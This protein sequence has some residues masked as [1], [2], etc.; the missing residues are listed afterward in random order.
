[1][2]VQG[3]KVIDIANQDRGNGIQTGSL[4]S[5]QICFEHQLALLDL[6]AILHMNFEALAAQT[7]SFQT[8]M[9]QNL[10][11]ILCYQTNGVASIKHGIHGS[12]TRGIYFTVIGNDCDTFTQNTLGK[13]RIGNFCYR[14]GLTSHRSKNMIGIKGFFFLTK[15]GIWIGICGELGADISMLPTFL[16]MGI[17]ELSVSP[18]AVLPVR[19]AI[20]QS[21]AQTCT[22]E[23]L[24]C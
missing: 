12:I 10:S 22:L 15:A 6:L 3:S 16:A 1:M 4:D 18:S 17:D 9:D 19:A 23:M 7:N 20:R 8:H 21:I 5:F 13:S 2:T 14:H 11:A 24:E